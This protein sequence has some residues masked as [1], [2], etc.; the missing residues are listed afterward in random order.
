MTIQIVSTHL[1]IDTQWPDIRKDTK[2]GEIFRMF[3]APKDL[4]VNL[5]CKL[6]NKLTL[7]K[8]HTN[9]R[10][11]DA[12]SLT[13]RDKIWRCILGLTIEMVKSTQIRKIWI[14]LRLSVDKVWNWRE[15]QI[16]KRRLKFYNREYEYIFWG[17][18]ELIY[19]IQN[20]ILKY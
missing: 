13:H 8:D 5:V 1:F 4:W 9:V 17:V 11:R 20:S 19:N 2:N 18:K 10:F 14:E 3:N 6:T 15:L 7:T 12:T 16:Y